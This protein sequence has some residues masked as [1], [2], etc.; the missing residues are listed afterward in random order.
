MHLQSIP[1]SETGYFSKLVLDYLADASELRPFYQHRPDSEGIKAAIAARKDFATDKRKV[2]TEAL[3]NQYQ[4][5]ELTDAVRKNI[6][7]LGESNTYTVVTGHQLNICTGP[8]YFIYKILSIIRLAQQ[9]EME[10][11]DCRIVP[12]FW[13]ASED[14]DL[15]EVDHLHLFGKRYRWETEQKGPVGRMAP[16]SLVPLLEEL[17]TSFSND[18]TGLALIDLFE[19]G[20]GNYPTMAQATRFIVHSLFGEWG[21]VV[22]DG[23]D[24]LLKTVFTETMLEDLL[25]QHSHRLVTESSRALEVRYTA[26]AMPREINFFYMDGDLRERIIAE[27]DS[28]RIHNTNKQFSETELIELLQ[29]HPERIS[30]NVITRPL[31]QESI[32]PNIVY[33]GGGAEVAYWFQLRSCFQQYNIPFPIVN[34]RHSFLLI[35]APVQQKLQG[36]GQSY[37][38][39]FQELEAWKKAFV[40]TNSTTITTLVDEKKELSSFF[41]T[42]RAK[43][44]NIDGSLPAAV[45]A[46]HTRSI[47]ALENWE[48]RMTKAAK[49]QFETSL[50][51]LEKI[52]AR[53]F[54]EGELQERHNTILQHPVLSKSFGSI[55]AQLPAFSKEFHILTENQAVASE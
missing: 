46:E 8:L 15:A 1:F 38:D 16:T 31:Y 12:V 11:P 20:Y 43:L 7:A 6:F 37:K 50:Q 32:L 9:A 5:I 13:M 24:P 33:T 40:L 48:G 47:K 42:L 52:K 18:S 44:G 39:T 36:L 26:Q 10:N 34:L 51:K 41:M 27:Q 25:A 21:L 49:Q 30:P 29:K 35:E 4:G 28:Y 54:P 19:Q 53:L 22:L 2:L 23:D 45:E 3:S 14:H 55:L 17:R